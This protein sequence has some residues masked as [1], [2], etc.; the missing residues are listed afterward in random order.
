MKR[1][2][3]RFAPITTAIVGLLAL[4]AIWTQRDAIIDWLAL[5][6]YT[7]SSA[8]SQLADDATMTS[9]GRNFFYVNDPQIEDRAAFNQDCNSQREKALILGCYHGNRQGI[10]L[11]KVDTSELKGVEQVTA[12][13]EMLHQAYDRLSSTQR[14][15]IN[16]LLESY[17]E[18]DLRDEQIKEQIAAYEKSEPNDVINELHSLFGTEVGNLPAELED[19]YKQ[20]FTDRAKVVQYYNSYQ[21]AFRSRQAQID[22]YDKDLESR[23]I[24]IDTLEQSLEQKLAQLDQ[25]KAQMD[26]YRRNNVSAYNNLVGP[27]NTLVDVY[28]SGLDDLKQKIA[29]YNEIVV[30]RNAI[31]LEQQQLQQDLSSLP[32]SVQ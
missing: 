18:H 19:Y 7:P 23:K 6:D 26:K 10:Y 30:K 17:R 14:A 32:S 9:K 31:A 8:I 1:F 22:A 4:G 15:H 16:Q 13:H 21:D 20:Y 25:M 24:Q 3:L 5:R 28:N 11:F 2:W 12:A 29:T 27:Y